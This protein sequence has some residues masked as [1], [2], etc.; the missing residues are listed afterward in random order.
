MNS[1]YIRKEVREQL[2]ENNTKC[3][4]YPNSN[5][6][7]NYNCPMWLLYNGNFDSSGFEIDHINE[8]SKT[9]NNDLENLQLLCACCHKVKTKLFIKNKCTFTYSEIRN[10]SCLMDIV[11]D[12]IIKKR[13]KN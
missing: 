4:N 6:I 7:L 12:N 2:F 9:C 3:A 10:G 13:K 8:F 11:E 1:R 5:I